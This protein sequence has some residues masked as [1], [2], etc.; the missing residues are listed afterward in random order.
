[1]VNIYRERVIILCQAGV[2]ETQAQRLPGLLRCQGVAVR[3]YD[4]HRLCTTRHRP[5]H[6]QA[7][8]RLHPTW[9][10]LAAAR[11]TRSRLFL[12]IAFSPVVA[13]VRFSSNPR[14]RR[15]PCLDLAVQRVWLPPVRST[16]HL[17]SWRCPR[18]WLLHL[19]FCAQSQWRRLRSH[20]E[21]LCADL[22][23]LV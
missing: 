6:R 5:S 9:V 14:S 8:Q 11:Y 2:S 21:R 15:C 4:C 22:G 17:R 1:L 7:H 18:F 10:E 12:D 20:K 3:R 13:V 19:L 16:V 23:G